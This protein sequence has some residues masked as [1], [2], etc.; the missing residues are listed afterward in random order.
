MLNQLFLKLHFGVIHEFIMRSSGPNLLIESFIYGVLHSRSSF[1][2]PKLLVFWELRLGTRF[3]FVLAV[4]FQRNSGILEALKYVVEQL[5]F[6][7]KRR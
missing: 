5:P 4:G 7:I 3:L 6:V 1:K 2:G